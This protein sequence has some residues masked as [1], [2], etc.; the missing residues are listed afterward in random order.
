MNNI[1]YSIR[2][3]EHFII[4]KVNKILLEIA[5]ILIFFADFT[6][7]YVMYGKRIKKL[8][9]HYGYS[10][11]ELAEKLGIPSTTLSFWERAEYPS[12]EGIIKICGIFNMSSWEFFIDDYSE[13]KKILPSFVTTDD[14]AILHLLNNHIDVAARMQVKRVFVEIIKLAL[15]DKQDEMKHLPEFQQLFRLTEYSQDDERIV[16]PVHDEQKK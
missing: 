7:I 1:L 6:N 12:L 4:H 13:M 16:S 2:I 3:F 15:A 14:A 8:R 5:N 11:R 10:Q 9:E